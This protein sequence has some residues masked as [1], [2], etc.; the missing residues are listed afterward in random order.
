LDI[1]YDSCL[2]RQEVMHPDYAAYQLLKEKVEN[3]DLGKKTGKGF[4][5]WSNG[6]PTID[7]NKK[8]DKIEMRD[9]DLVKL[10]EAAK[11]VEEGVATPKDIDL[12]MVL[13][14]GDKVGPIENSKGLDIS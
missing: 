10:N 12:A 1:L 14:T 4:Y 2:Y 9:I 5:D 7:L 3:G 6:R 8:T 11:L 13:G